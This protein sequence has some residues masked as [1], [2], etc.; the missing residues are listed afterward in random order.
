VRNISIGG[1]RPGKG[2]KGIPQSLGGRKQT[3]SP[4]VGGRKIEKIPRSR[5][6]DPF[7][8]GRRRGERAR[9]F[10]ANHG[11]AGS[12]R[13]QGKRG[14]G[15]APMGELHR[16]SISAASA[17]ERP[18]K[19]KVDELKKAVQKDDAATLQLAVAQSG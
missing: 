11:K 12:K 2:Q 6:G 15:H 18:Q 7:H 16:R 14:E 4:L 5:K 3:A 1:R 19:G 10:P 8:Q 17:E 9:T 13:E